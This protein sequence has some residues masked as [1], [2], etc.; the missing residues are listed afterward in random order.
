MLN[1][2]FSL[3][4]VLLASNQSRWFPVHPTNSTMTLLDDFS[5]FTFSEAVSPVKIAVLTVFCLWRVEVNSRFVLMLCINAE[6][7][8]IFN[9]KSQAFQTD[10]I[11]VYFSLR[12]NKTPILLRYFHTKFFSKTENTAP[13]DISVASITMW[14]LTQQWFQ[15]IS[16]IL[17]TF[18]NHFEENHFCGH[19]K[20]FA[21]YL[22]IFSLN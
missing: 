13:F 8:Q 17:C 18:A 22:L 6:T 11:A 7:C 15:T 2:L 16:W 1:T 19:P 4:F 21:A 5:L 9:G 10:Y 20:P 3:S 14:N 12:A